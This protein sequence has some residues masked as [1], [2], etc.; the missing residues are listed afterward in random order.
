M[1]IGLRVFWPPRPDVDA[2]Y[3]VPVR[4]AGTLPTAAFGFRV[5][6]DTLAV[7]LTVPVIRVRRGLSPAGEH[8]QVATEPP[9][10]GEWRL[11]AVRHAWHTKER[12]TRRPPLPMELAP[13]ANWCQ[14]LSPPGAQPALRI[15]TTPLA[16]ASPDPQNLAHA[17]MSLR[18]RVSMSPRWYAAS[19]LSRT[20]W[21]SAASATSRGKLVHSA[22]QSRKVEGKP[23]TVTCRSSKPIRG[24]GGSETNDPGDSVGRWTRRK[25]CNGGVGRYAQAECWRCV[26][27]VN[28]VGAQETGRS[29]LAAPPGTNAVAGR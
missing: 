26:L 16:G 29:L 14:S 12:A 7:R 22:T 15:V 28:G 19:V 4:R 11:R 2:S 27:F 18:R 10:P 8:P 20:T 23:C 3:A 6:P 9:Q 5:A 13:T 24:A 25:D 17:S 1:T 21:A